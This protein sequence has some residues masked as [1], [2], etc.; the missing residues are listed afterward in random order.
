MD[1]LPQSDLEF[2][3]QSLDPQKDAA[4]EQK[5]I[6]DALKALVDEFDRNGSEERL[7]QLAEIQRCLLLWHGEPGLYWNEGARS[8]QSV[9]DAHEAG[10]VDDEDVE[11]YDR[12]INF[13]RPLLESVIA[14]AS[15]EIP[16]IHFVPAK[17]SDPLDILTAREATKVS[18]Y[19]DIVND[20]R[21]R[22]HDA[23]FILS[24]QHFAAG[25][26]YMDE[27]G[28]K[29]G[30]DDEPV[31]GMVDKTRQMDICPNCVA[32]MDGAPDAPPMDPSQMDPSMYPMGQLPDQQMGQKICPNCQSSVVPQPDE[33]TYQEED[34]VGYNQVPRNKVCIEIYGPQNVKLP[35]WVKNLAATPYL[36]FYKEVPVAF[37]A[38][39]YEDKAEAILQTAQGDNSKYDRWARDPI[40]GRGYGSGR[41]DR[42]THRLIWVRDW[43]LNG[44]NDP[45]LRK[46]VKEQYP[47]GALI[48]MVN[49]IFVKC[50][51]SK[52][53]EH[54]AI[55]E[56]AFSDTVHDDPGGKAIIPTCEIQNDMIQLWVENIK[57]NIPQTFIDAQLLD[58]KEY[59][60]ISSRPGL[61]TPVKRIPGM[62]ISNGIHETRAVT[63]SQESAGLYHIA[64]QVSQF[65]S[66]A[67]PSIFG[68]VLQSG[69]RTAH[70][71]D[72][73]RQAAL[74]RIALKLGTVN[75]W[76]ARLKLKAVEM[77]K[78]NAKKSQEYS[79]RSGQSYKPVI[80][81][82][83]N[84][85]GLID[86]ALPED[87]SMFPTTWSQKRD[88]M[89]QALSSGNMQMIQLLF[90][91]E[92]ST[93]L[94]ELIGI[95]E[96]FVPGEQDRMKQL[97]EI[98]ELLK[99]PPIELPQMGPMGA[100]MQEHSS[101]TPDPHTDNGPAHILTL[102]SW[103]NSEE[104]REAQKNNPEGHAN[105]MA[106]LMEHIQMMPPPMPPAGPGGPKPGEKPGGAPGD[107]GNVAPPPQGG[108]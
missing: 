8:W 30:Y 84:L 93:L 40:V 95:P 102:Q 50:V 39:M 43:A 71:Y 15:I 104:G 38:Q 105:V 20:S 24:N 2:L 49:E 106:H 47:D 72:A 55:T 74:Q 1:Q 53:D 73:S 91:P 103:L 48:I 82:P 63:I 79:A 18:T 90:H 28:K 41:A 60:K 37:L 17:A 92:N 6:E 27:D 87:S 32:P 12:D 80:I 35:F 34:V 10:L 9:W 36:E 67:M 31:M 61:M 75:S 44:I 59:S 66:G 33:A 42:G 52:L 21:E 5:S 69:S 83:E 64:E 56:T 85:Q 51:A 86:H 97:W 54:W 46:K 76:W 108:M 107:P 101:I 94:K 7:W 45:T 26:L 78:A 99:S 68:G 62:N 29:Y 89:V 57:H 11:D 65:A 4:A 88:F 16:R 25:Y 100:Q 81:D 22:I 3:N 77:Y 58:L 13:Y 70:E 19:L 98:S 96:M 14:A 23:Y